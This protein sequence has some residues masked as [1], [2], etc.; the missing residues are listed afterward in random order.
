VV[1]FMLGGGFVKLSSCVEHVSS[2][3]MLSGSYD[4]PLSA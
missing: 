4:T 2:K 3:V 1:V